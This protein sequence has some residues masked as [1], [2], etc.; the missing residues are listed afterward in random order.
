M[1]IKFFISIIFMIL[2]V[3]CDDH[4]SEPKSASGISKASVEIPTGS[5]G[6]TAEQRNKIREMLQ[7]GPYR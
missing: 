1:K 3:G 2:F 5:D 4:N 6:L 7:T